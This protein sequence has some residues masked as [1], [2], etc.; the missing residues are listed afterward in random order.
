MGFL[1]LWRAWAVMVASVSED[2][3]WAA[4]PCGD[5]GSVVVRLKFN[6]FTPVEQYDDNQVGLKPSSHAGTVHGLVRL[7]RSMCV[8]LL[9]PACISHQCDAITNISVF[10]EWEDPRLIDLPENQPLP[11]NLWQPEFHVYAHPTCKWS[12]LF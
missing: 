8:W 1:F 7:R 12:F 10:Y 5:E 6:G 2:I 11:D 4:H 9:H 3:D